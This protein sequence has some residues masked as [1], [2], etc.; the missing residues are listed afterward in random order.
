MIRFMLEL[1]EVTV[2]AGAGEEVPVLL[3]E[4]TARFPRGEVC[5]LLGPSGSGKTTLVRAV[6]GIAE[7]SAG[8][9]HW[10]GVDLDLEDLPPSQIGYVPQFTISE[11]NL[12]AEENV[13]LALRLRVAGLAGAQLGA[14][15]TELLD[16]TGLASAA[17]TLSKHLSGGQRRRLALAMELASEPP[18]LLCDEVTSGLDARSER[19]ILDLLRRIARE[20]N[21]VVIVVTHGLRDLDFYDK[22]AVLSGGHIAYLGPPDTLAHYFRVDRPEE[23]FERLPQREAGEWHASWSKHRAHF[24]SA[25]KAPAPNAEANDTTA[26]VSILLPGAFRQFL[27]LTA[28]R[29]KIFFR[30]KGNI[31]LQI[32][33]VLGFPL[34]VAVFALD[35]LPAVPS[36]DAGLSGDVVRQLIEARTFAE[37]ASKAGSAVSGLILLQVILLGLL[38]ANN[39]AREIAGERAIY[40]KERFAGLNPAAYVAAKIAFLAV[41]V[42]LQSA[43][44]TWFVRTV[45]GFPG[46]GSQQFLFFLLVNA[47]LTATCLGIS[48]L[49]RTADQASLASIYLVGF[50]LPLSGAVLA[51]PAGLDAALRPFIAAYWSWSGGLQSL[52]ET[53]YYD[54]LEL[55]V[56]TTLSAASL[57]VWVLLLHIIF[58]ILIAWLGC[59][60]SAWDR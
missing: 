41:L 26:A 47:A 7:T 3:S 18:L 23:I 45:T 8:S 56:P 37:G 1:R 10:E 48:A 51:L 5:A 17:Q 58:G 25:H 21:R 54:V 14:R 11:E 33:L 13:V 34:V 19:E 24:E 49:A 52:R 57:C 30:D 50:Q 55:V 46:D 38:G 22:V 27:T 29:W 43:W 6:A 53:R 12:T 9:L 31:A 20:G 44:M 35:G 60:R 16:L 15:A 32:G 28:T 4:V 2:T 42:L 39:S 40:E 59:L 36:L